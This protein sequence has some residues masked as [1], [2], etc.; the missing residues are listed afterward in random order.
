MQFDLQFIRRA[1][2]DASIIGSDVPPDLSFSIDSRMMVPGDIFVAMPGTKFD[3]HDFVSDAVKK[4]AAGLI[5][6]ERCQTA[7]LG[8]IDPSHL[9]KMVVMVVADAKMALVELAR[10]WRVQFT[11]PVVAITGSVGKT[12]TRTI[13]VNILEGAGRR[14]VSSH[15]NQNT[16]LGVALT[17][18]RMRGVHDVAV[19]EVGISMRGEMQKIADLLRPTNA[20]ITN[21]GHQH[22]DGLGSMPDVVQ[23]KRKIFHYFTPKSVG[24]V[25]GDQS[26]LS[27]I[28]YPHPVVRFGSR[29]TNQ[30]QARKVQVTGGRMNF[31]LRVYAS[32]FE[33]SIEGVHTGVITNAL[34][35]ASL[36]HLLEVSH[37]LIASGISKPAIVPGRFEQRA[38]ANEQGIMI[39][40]SYNASPESVK[41]GLLAFERIET[42]IGKVVVLGDMCGLGNSAPFWHRQIGRFFAKVPT[43]VRVI[44]VGNLVHWTRKTL[45]VPVK[46]DVVATWHE[47]LEILRQELVRQQAAVLVNGS[48]DMGLENLVDACTN[49][50]CQ[51]PKRGAQQLRV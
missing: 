24:V 23:E 22:M 49:Q 48:R 36:A 43:L 37:E 14:V 2:P 38:L 7:V 21:V 47:A 33:V 31:I 39:N 16:L 30:V 26:I 1:L 19:F 6:E 27:A 25:Y 4:G 50:P 3:G 45:P 44:L 29:T 17:I 34:A 12:T 28:S 41:E 42:R 8:V 10:A 11:R 13:L 35:A 32:K 20:V 40:D 18:L 46:A 9:K 5:I 15:G 51:L